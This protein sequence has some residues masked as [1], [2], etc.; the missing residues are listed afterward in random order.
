MIK[1][2]P[3]IIEKLKQKKR[4][5]T[6]GKLKHSYPHS[7]RSK[8][9][10]VHRAT[11]QWFISME[12]HGLR[13]LAL[14]ALDET[15]FYPNKGKERIKSMIETRPDWCVSRQRVW[16][17]PLP[18]FI[19]KKNKEILIDDE[20]IEN[21][22][23]GFSTVDWHFSL[24]WNFPA[25]ANAEYGLPSIVVFDDDDLNPVTVLTNIGEIRWQLDNNLEIV[26]ENIVD[27]TPPISSSSPYHV[28]V[29]PGDDL[30][31]S[32][33]IQYDVSGV[34]IESLPEDGLVVLIETYY[35]SELLV[36][37]TDVNE[38]GTWTTGL[39]LP[40]RSLNDGLL[41]VSYSILGVVAPGE[42]ASLFQ[43]MI[44]VDDVRPVV[45]FSSVPL[46]LD[47]EDLELLQFSLQIIDAGGMPQG[48]LIVNWAFLRNSLIMQNGQSSASLPFVSENA[49]IWTYAGTLDF[50]EGVNVSLE[51]GDELIY[52]PN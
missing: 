33:I 18:I 4:L 35:G 24:D 13:K 40:S 26:V 11:Q 7:W 38:D 34:Q 48:D 47:D 8:A 16:G 45:Q 39:I 31:V 10:L 1:A 46:T 30:T 28:Y 14:K 49:A 41:T 27:N 20:V 22:D 23:D 9:P 44:T 29:Q 52:W 3:I 15:K 43:S 19:N 12:S 36:V 21:I 17:V 6:N 50:T 5:I 32:G 37:E 51:E 2:N 42:D 25:M